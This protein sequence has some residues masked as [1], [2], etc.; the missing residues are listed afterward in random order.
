MNLTRSETSTNG[1]RAAEP[2]RNRSCRTPLFPAVAAALLAAAAAEAASVS[3]TGVAQRWPWNNKVDISYT[4]EGGQTR[5]AGVY[6]GMRF[7]L[8]AN[9]T[10]YEID[11]ASIGASTE[12]GAHVATWTAPE[13]IVA[14]AASMSATLFTTNVPSGDDYMIVDLDTGSVTYEG[15]FA[16]QSE[17]DARYNTDEF[18]TA[19]LVLRKIPKWSEV[20]SLP[21]GAEVAALGGYPTGHSEFS[22]DNAPA[23]WRTERAYYT[24][25]FLV[26]QSQYQKLC[27][28][29]PSNKKATIAGNVTAHRPVEMV[30]WNGLRASAPATNAIPAVAAAGEGSFLQRLNRL[31]GNRY[32]FDLPTE[33][34]HEIAARA[35]A[36]TVYPWGDAIDT[37]CF[38]CSDNSGGS[39]VAVGSRLPNGWG[40]YDA[41]GNVN[42]MCLDEVGLAQLANASDPFV[43]FWRGLTTY[44]I[45]MRGSLWDTVSTHGNFKVSHRDQMAPS[46]V[47]NYA[48][49]RVYRIA[50]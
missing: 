35:G 19:K 29:N 28:T 7:L 31:T 37:S 44:R 12:N 23:F 3:I 24:G 1:N 39:T 6:C 21:N 14:T 45:V 10:E 20:E 9:G 43:P 2:R 26:T 17:S 13:G 15:V 38:V 22:S 18:K 34:M 4:V 36:T 50:E 41:V 16:T 8:S 32:A 48:G 47:G 49:F 46:W 42:Q 25:V 33:I 27:G 30:S 40:I 5:S 11:G